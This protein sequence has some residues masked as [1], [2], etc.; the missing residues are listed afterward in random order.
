MLP[1]G[2]HTL[3]WVDDNGKTLWREKINLLPFETMIVSMAAQQQ[4]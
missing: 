2:R 3:S 4:K 1:Y